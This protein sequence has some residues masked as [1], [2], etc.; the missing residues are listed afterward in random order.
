MSG[1]EVTI[2]VNG[3]EL[4][5]I[6]AALRI[7]IPV[8]KLADAPPDVRATIEHLKRQP[9]IALP[10]P[11]KGEGR[12]D[13]NRWIVD[14]LEWC[15]ETQMPP[16]K[17]LV[18]LIAQQLGVA[19]PRRS[20]ARKGDQKL[21]AARLLAENP[22]MK[23]REL[24]RHCGVSEKLVRNWRKDANFKGTLVFLKFHPKA[25]TRIDASG[26]ILAS[27]PNGQISTR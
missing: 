13:L 1:R 16:N 9:P 5:T 12:S 4:A 7:K 11:V 6:L 27:S 24:A 25:T 10:T 20:G 21:T 14:R 2:R 17:G 26:K 23:T 3:S 18:D 19:R 15:A 22:G 8:K